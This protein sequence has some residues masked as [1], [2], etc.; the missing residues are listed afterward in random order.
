MH[1]DP[2]FLFQI[3]KERDLEMQFLEV[4]FRFVHHDV[5]VFP[6]QLDI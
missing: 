4:L 1:G 3:P 6:F 5:I 2:P